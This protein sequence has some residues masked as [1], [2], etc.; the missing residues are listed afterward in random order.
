LS[1]DAIAI[2]LINALKSVTYISV[3]VLTVVSAQSVA[4]WVLTMPRP[5]G[6]V[7]TNDSE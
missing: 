7:Y 5:V 2:K 6:A 1:F 4:Y 3:Q